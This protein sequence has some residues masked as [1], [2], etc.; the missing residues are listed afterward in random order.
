MTDPK[1]E[2]ENVEEYLD[3][4]LIPALQGRLWPPEGEADGLRM[5]AEELECALVKVRARIAQ[6][7]EAEP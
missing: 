4:E 5:I 1:S 3:E 6:L 7:E 2:P